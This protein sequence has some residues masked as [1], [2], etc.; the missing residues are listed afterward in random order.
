M[1]TATDSKTVGSKGA[2]KYH[3]TVR[4]QEQRAALPAYTCAECD[5]FYQALGKPNGTCAHGL[6]A[7]RHRY[8]ASPPRT[9][10]NYWSIDHNMETAFARSDDDDDD[11]TIVAQ[12]VTVLNTPVPPTPPPTP[13]LSAAA[14]PVASSSKPVVN[15]KDWLLRSTLS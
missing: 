6:S 9:P 7:S 1:A 3:E 15:L 12:V 5:A 4:K 13:I 14:A 10:P 8:T 2:R 11:V